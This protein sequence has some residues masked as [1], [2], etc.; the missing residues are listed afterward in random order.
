MSKKRHQLKKGN[1][2]HE[3]MICIQRTGAEQLLPRLKTQK[4]LMNRPPPQKLR[5]GTV[6][7][8]KPEMGR[9]N[10]LELLR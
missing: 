6:R 4:T 9:W 3:K 5:E 1:L 8:P 10:L 7:K 2:I